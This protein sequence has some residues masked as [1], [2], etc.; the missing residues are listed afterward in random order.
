MAYGVT[1]NT[2]RGHQIWSRFI[3]EVCAFPPVRD[4]V[5]LNI[6]DGLRGCYEGGPGAVARYIW[7]AKTIWVATDPVAADRIAYDTI[8]AKREA[9]GV[10]AE[11]EVAYREYYLDQLVR[12]ERFGLGVYEKDKIDYRLTELG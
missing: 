8:F 7:N 4:K 6:I 2:G 12:A 1:S 11:N 9:E 10:L 3:A 5:V